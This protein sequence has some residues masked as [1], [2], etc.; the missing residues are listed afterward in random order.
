MGN[1]RTTTLARHRKHP[2]HNLL[3]KIFKNRRKRNHPS[4]TRTKRRNANNNQHVREHHASPTRRMPTEIQVAPGTPESMVSNVS[5]A[6]GLPPDLPRSMSKSMFKSVLPEMQSETEECSMDRST[7]TWTSY[8]NKNS[9]SGKSSKRNNSPPFNKSMFVNGDDDDDDQYSPKNG[10]VRNLFFG[11]PQKS[12]FKQN[13]SNTN[14]N[15][16]DLFWS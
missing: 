9:G 3:M 11:S 6:T 5:G 12:M 4:S 15:H 13:I 2:F 14:N 16:I 10:P 7:F 8:S 1:T